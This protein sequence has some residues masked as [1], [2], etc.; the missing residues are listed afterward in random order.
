MN[1]RYTL[2]ILTIL[3]I[4]LTSAAEV[5]SGETIF[6]ELDK[7]YEYYSIVGNSTPIN[8]EITQ[9][10][11]N[12]TIVFDKYTKNDSFELIFFD[13]E[14]EVIYSHSS[15]GGGGG[16]RTIIKEKN[17]TEYI[18]VSD[19]ID[20]EIEVEKEIETEVEKTSKWTYILGILSLV[21]LIILIKFIV[22]NR[23][24]RGLKEYE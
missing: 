21:L 6:L 18:E 1:M 17:N 12:L 24:E 9:E 20:R 15:S 2:L 14:K 5:Y 11:N 4:S 16:T 7:P 3:L 23:N 8:L 19:Y 22:K 13:K 10:G